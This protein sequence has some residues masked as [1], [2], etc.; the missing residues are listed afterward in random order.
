MLSASDSDA[1]MIIFFAA[2]IFGIIGLWNYGVDLHHFLRL[3][4]QFHSDSAIEVR[5]GVFSQA[6]RSLQVQYSAE[7]CEDFASDGVIVSA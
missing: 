5:E 7:R 2:G 6:E 4:E 1:A 3:L